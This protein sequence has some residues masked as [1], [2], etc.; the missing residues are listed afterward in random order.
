M[1]SSPAAAAGAAASRKKLVIF[2]A[3]EDLAASEATGPGSGCF[4]LRRRG[5]R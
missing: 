4:R 3:E 1:A 5:G 2:G